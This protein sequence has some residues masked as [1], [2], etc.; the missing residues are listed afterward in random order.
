MNLDKTEGL[1][2]G[3]LKNSNLEQYHNIIFRKS[4]V[5]CLGVYLGH[6]RQ[7]CDELNWNT[8]LSQLEKILN[9]WQKRNLNIF[10][11]V[12]VINSICIPKIIYLCSVTSVPESIIDKIEHL[13]NQFLWSGKA[14]ASKKC[15][16]NP[17]EKG[18]LNVVDIRSKI[19]TLKMQWLIRWLKNSSWGPI[20]ESFLEK[21]GCGLPMLFDLN[22]E[23]LKD[24]PA[25][26]KLPRF[27]QDVW[28]A[29]YNFKGTRLAKSMNDYDF[30]SQVLWGNNI[31][32]FQNN[33]LF[34]PN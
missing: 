30:L 16:I 8:K 29:Y 23:K 18:G 13:V 12:T 9:V 7:L 2:L 25:L 27:Y 28:Q 32:K 24:F 19:Q 10:G 11:K 14:R 33:C 5:K 17:V 21:T 4:P 22:I 31:F 1:L 15:I 6:D 20:A 3:N 26:L 34:F